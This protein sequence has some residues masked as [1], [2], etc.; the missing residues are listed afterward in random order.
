M[1]EH[2]PRQRQ[3]RAHQHRRPDDRVEPCNVFADDV[4]VGRPPLREHRLVCPE[5]GG[6]GVIDQRVE[7]DIDHARRIVRHRDAPR[8]SGAADRDVVEAG[9]EQ[10]ENLVAA[11]VRLHEFRMRRE[12]RDERVAVL[13]EAE[14]VVLLLDPLDGAVQRA[15]PVHQVLV[16]LERLAA[17]AVP[18]LVEPL[19]D[20]T[21]RGDQAHQLLDRRLVARLGRP[22][23]VVVGDVEE[24]PGLA[25]HALH[26][27]AVRQRIEPFFP[28]LAIDVLGVLVVPHD[29]EGLETRQPLVARDRVRRDLLVGGAQVRTAVHVVDR[30]RQIKAPAHPIDCT[31]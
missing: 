6:G 14:E 7:P 13:R 23:E 30:R 29:E 19:V 21:L 24:I 8:L 18:S 27:V 4:Q 20:V 15:L 9:F 17:D 2:L 1:A 12:V 11:G 3:P 25:E 5:A 28:G 22:D 31:R 10:L 26:P 16:L